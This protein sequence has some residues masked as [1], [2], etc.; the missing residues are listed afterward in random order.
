MAARG[1]ITPDRAKG[2]S[3]RPIEIVMQRK[4]K[5]IGVSAVVDNILQ[6][7]KSRHADLDENDLFQGHIQ[8]Y[9]TVNARMQ[10][11][12]NRAL[13]QGLSLYEKR[14]PSA[15]G[16]IQGS[17]VVLRNSDASI[18]AETGGRQFYKG[19]IQRS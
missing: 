1:F 15:K 10:E 17:V 16:I 3:Q 4:D 5:M 8:V 12:S 7:L 13:E 14:H 18:L 11:I 2:A 6:E 19:R 9:S